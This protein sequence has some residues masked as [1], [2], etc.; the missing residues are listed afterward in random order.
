MKFSFSIAALALVLAGSAMAQT[1]PLPLPP[2]TGGVGSVVQSQDVQLTP[3]Q[4]TA[5]L[6]AVKRDNRK[7]AAPSGVPA[8]VGA[9]LPP[10]LELY[11]LPDSALAEIPA[12]K[13]FKY[14]SVENRIVL[15]DPTTMRVVDILE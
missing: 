12:A 6:Q 14:T 5:I 10:S 9:E 3:T 2:K 8:R 7:I 4:K 15:V 1:E 11:A 13:Q